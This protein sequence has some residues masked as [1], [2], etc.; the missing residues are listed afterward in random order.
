MKPALKLIL[1]IS[2]FLVFPGIILAQSSEDCL[3]CH[4]QPGLAMNKKGQEI[5]LTVSKSV[6]QQSVHGSLSC[7]DCHQ[8]FNPAEMP[9]AKKITPVKCQTCHDVTGY[10]NSI[11][12]VAL[13]AE[14]CKACH[15]T[16][17]ILVPAN[18]DSKV[19]RAHVAGTCAKCHKEEDDHYA[20]SKHG[21]AM[22]E[23]SK[24]APSCLDCHGGAH[25]ILPASEPESVLYK[26]KEPDVCLKCHLNNPQVRGEVGL[27][28]GFINGYKESVHGVNLAKG[29]LKAASCS[30]CHGAHDMAIGSSPLSLVSKFKVPD[31]C[32]KCHGQIV[33]T[34]YDSIHG[35]AL[36]AGNPS[37]PNCTNCHGE[38]QIFAAADPRS[39]V[40]N[41]NVAAR[42]CAECHNSVALTQKYGLASQRFT[43]F[44][45]SF[46]GLASRAGAIQ[47]ANC[48]SCHGVHN[49]KPSS[50]PTSTIYAANLATTCGKCHQ[51]ANLNFSKGAVHVVVAPA[52]EPVLYW[53]R[54]FYLGMIVIVVGGMLVHN[55]LD[56]LVKTRHHFAVRRGDVTPEHF[57][58]ATYLRMTLSERIQH[59][60][61]ASSFIILVITG[62]MLKFP[63]AWWVVPIRQVSEKLFNVRG[64]IHRVAGVAMIGISLYHVYYI[65]RVQRGKQLIRDLLPKPQDVRDF[66]QTLK[67]YL[68]ISKTKPK[69]GRFAYIEKA[70]YWALIWGVIIMGATGIVLWFNNY[71]IGLL[72]LLGWNIAEAIHYYE[73][74]LATLA[75]VVW[76]FYFVIF[77]PSIYPLNTAFITGHITEEEM[78]EEHPLELEQILAQ[79]E[80]AGEPAHQA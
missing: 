48:A 75:I 49:I 36:K 50:D 52:T 67:Y 39:T 35:K 30:N 63:D 47:V 2:V 43:S 80:A 28:A 7:V 71:F 19:N 18:P 42:V 74:W 33:A 1:V 55:W 23:G 31:T 79:Q 25:T 77:N 34:Y 11:H 59:G 15:G 32:G 69:Y 14:G 73:A 24:G 5:Q 26:T 51:G 13:A 76:H 29:D 54:A 64:I 44:E 22:A 16:H 6:L 4:S 45:D 56:F 38:H 70:E 12:G 17:N 27:S 53:L 60:T 57:G 61:M 66:W 10:D 37:A 20:R 65:L 68:R 41:R 78:A 9:H 62:F 40:S 46:H 21:L 58:S 3:A 72:T 8:G